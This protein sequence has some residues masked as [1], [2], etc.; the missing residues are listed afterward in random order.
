M[1]ATCLIAAPIIGLLL[2]LIPFGG[3][4]EHVIN[5]VFFLALGSGW[6]SLAVL[7][8]RYGS[9]PQRWAL[10]PALILLGAGVASVSWPGS[11]GNVVVA[12]I[13][14]PI[15]LGLV[16]FIGREAHRHLRSRS[17]RWVLYPVLS[18]LTL[19]AAGGTYET[20]AETLDAVAHPAPG[21]M[22]AVDGHRLHLNCRGT[23]RPT[24]VLISGF[25]EVSS[26]WSWIAG[27]VSRD[28]RV[29]SYDPAGRAWSES[30]EESQNASAR[31]RDL[32]DLLRQAGETG[33]HVL[34]G[35]SF[36]GL[37]ARI[38]AARYPE[39]VAGMVLL[40]ATHPDMFRLPSY[41]GIYE[42]YRR[43]SALFPSL[44]RLGVGRLAYASSRSG[45]PPQ[46]RDEILA[47]LSTARLARDQRDEWAQGPAA[48]SQAR[49][50]TTIGD[51]PLVIVTAARGAQDGW[52]PLQQQLTELST[53][54]VQRLLSDAEHSGL[55][56]NQRQAAESSRAI[57]DVI[58]AVRR[59]TPL[60]AE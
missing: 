16:V 5:G 25:G 33:P 18:L 26:A 59:S 48:M 23:G 30:G 36:G 42:V 49:S 32:H 39:D 54:V 9:Q 38:F 46:P 56:E 28:T 52:L 24:V 50:L 17:R 51:K 35:H 31:A 19:A 53:N 40:D 11:V 27:D 55:L 15:L 29:C 2:V 34:V 22:V 44:A 6:G 21:R 10:A 57:R 13:W 4:P 60:G 12:W 58:N 20:I 7:T 43:I 1:V 41:P 3:A 8:A 14:P 37:Y 45:L 47:F